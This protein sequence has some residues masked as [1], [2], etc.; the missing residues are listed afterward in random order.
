MHFISL[1]ICDNLE[2]IWI[3]FINLLIPVS[4]QSFGEG[5]FQSYLTGHWA[6]DDNWLIRNACRKLKNHSGPQRKGVGHCKW[7]F[8]LLC[9]TGELTVRSHLTFTSQKV[10]GFFE[11]PSPCTRLV[12][13]LALSNEFMS[14][15]A[16]RR[17]PLWDVAPLQG[18][19]RKLFSFTP[20]LKFQ[21]KFWER[22]RFWAYLRG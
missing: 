13:F 12:P 18:Y 1:L 15:H 5:A 6:I 16:P 3:K 10:E 8:E 7:T 22:D 17:H 19:G 20:G 21:T 11:Y 2:L 4:V 14:F 9:T